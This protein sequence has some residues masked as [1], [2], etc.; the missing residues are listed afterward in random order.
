V[1]GCREEN[2]PISAYPRDTLNPVNERALS[3][4]YFIDAH[5]PDDD[6][7]RD[8]FAWL[9]RSAVEGGSSRAAVFVSG[10][11]QLESLGRAIGTDAADGLHK[12]REVRLDGVVI[13]ALTA[14]KLPSS[15]EEG[16]I[17]AVWVDD[18]QLDKLDGLRAPGLCAIPWAHGDIDGWR[19][20]WDPIDVRTGQNVGL[21]EAIENPVV[22]RAMESLTTSVNLSTGLGHPSDKESAIGMFRILTA[23]GEPFE[24][25]QIRAWAVRHGWQPRHA[26]DLAVLAEKFKAGKQVRGGKRKMWRD[27]VI[28]IWRRESASGAD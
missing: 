6:A 10:L 14:R 11:R 3:G 23:E 26:R 7:V 8:G 16:P 12:D 4:R 2:S 28:E 18:E 9:L 21:E 24:P 27:D 22:V 15:F 13:E 5:G 17:L 25:D 19:A 20:A 1:W